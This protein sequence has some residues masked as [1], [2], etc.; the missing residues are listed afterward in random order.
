MP[1]IA[2]YDIETGDAGSRLRWTGPGPFVRLCGVAMDDGPVWVT[3]DPRQ[4]LRALDAADW[5]VGHNIIDYDN[6]A[7]AAHNRADYE[8][9]CAKSIDTYPW[10]KVEDPPGSRHSKP[11]GEKG[12]YSLDGIARRNGNP[13]KTDDLP[14]LALRWAVRELGAVRVTRKDGTPTETPY[15]TVGEERL[16]RAEMVRRGFALIPADEPDYGAYLRGDVEA[17]RDV[18]RSMGGLDA[19]LGSE[20]IQREM[21][22]SHFKGR[23]TLTGWRTDTALLAQRVAEEKERKQGAEAWLA[24]HCGL[25][26]TK[27]ESHG[28]GASKVTTTVRVKAPLATKEGR[29]ALEAAFRAAGAVHLPRTSA[30]LLALSGDAMGDGTWVWQPPKGSD[31]KRRVVP[32]MLRIYGGNSQVREICERVAV[33]AATVA[34]YQ[35]IQDYLIGDRSHALTGEDQSSSRWA[36]VKPALANL[37]KRGGKVIQRA[38]LI[39]D[40]G[41]V[42][43][44]VDADQ[45]DMRGVAGHCQD[46]AYMANFA[47]GQDAHSMVATAVFGRDRCGCEGDR[48]TCVWRERAKACGHGWN[49]GMG[50]EGLVINQ[51]VEREVAVQFDQMMTES[52]PGLCAWRD[53]LRER[54]RAGEL[55]DNGFGR[56]MRCD[57]GRA[58][59]Q[60]PAL[61]GQGCAR[62]LVTTGV[63][64]FLERFPEGWTML[65]GFV[66]DEVIL[67]VPVDRKEEIRDL[68]VDS[69]TWEWRGVPITAGA[70]LFGHNWTQCYPE[71]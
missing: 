34:K 37:G 26:L 20:Y 4:L 51:G 60:A 13:G 32:G 53:E 18:F 25:P 71:K 54:A 9:L 16:D 65:R 27:E 50:V 64:R 52:Y 66:H 22:I 41:E 36:S 69:M 8:A 70:S 1:R 31:Q 14:A 30:G 40:E 7:L 57:P 68:L 12:Y 3:D 48:H 5:I 61:V 46:P 33:V 21:R 28:R 63:L 10:A 67:S 15:W 35:E 19:F 47:P 42:L 62:D 6:M 38:P 2:Y 29:A 56:L 45:V 11:W 23:M 55:L 49:Y 39:A 43:I 24:Q 44:A 59:T 58:H 17:G